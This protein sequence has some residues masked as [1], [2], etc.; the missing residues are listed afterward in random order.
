MSEIKLYGT[1]YETQGIGQRPIIYVDATYDY[2]LRNWRTQNNIFTVWLE[3]AHPHTGEN[4]PVLYPNESFA[5]HFRDGD[6]VI[7]TL[8]VRPE[9]RGNGMKLLDVVAR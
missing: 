7:V 2:K 1:F 5:R 4:S 6:A 8:D 3:R 9:K